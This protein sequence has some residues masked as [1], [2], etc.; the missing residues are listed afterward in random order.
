MIL[1]VVGD[2]LQ[3]LSLQRIPGLTAENQRRFTWERQSTFKGFRLNVLIYSASSFVL[4][5]LS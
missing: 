4:S 2:R 1:D 3:N 5:S